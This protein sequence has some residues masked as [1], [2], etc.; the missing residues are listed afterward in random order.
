[1]EDEK[2]VIDVEKGGKAKVKGLSY[3]AVLGAGK[4]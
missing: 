1:M 3:A 2:E 4:A